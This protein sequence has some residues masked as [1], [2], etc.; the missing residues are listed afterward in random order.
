MIA[1]FHY[2]SIGIKNGYR[3][4]VIFEPTCAYVRWAHEYV[5]LSVCRWSVTRKKARGGGV[6]PF[7]SVHL[8]EKSRRIL[9]VKILA[10]GLIST[11]SCIFFSLKLLHRQWS[12]HDGSHL[13]FQW[14]REDP[15]LTLTHETFDLDPGD[16]S[17]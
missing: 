6:L 13:L 5:S 9:G 16:L 10:G 7:C 11:S 2:F 4:S 8:K 12:R 15:K 17:T 14:K 3:H 1:I